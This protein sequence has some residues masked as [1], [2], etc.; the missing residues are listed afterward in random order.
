MLSGESAIGLYGQ[1]ALSVLRMTSS[2][3]ETWGRE[4]SQQSLLHQHQ[5]GVSLPDRIAEE[6]C[7][8]AAEMGNFSF[9]L[10]KFCCSEFQYHLNISCYPLLEFLIQNLLISTH[11]ISVN[12]F[13][14]D[15]FPDSTYLRKEREL[16]SITT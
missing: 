8:S 6:I 3:I 15:C 2:R 1:K 4:E 14:H 11:Q 12:E 10:S 5:L 9:P 13:K 7:N 16:V